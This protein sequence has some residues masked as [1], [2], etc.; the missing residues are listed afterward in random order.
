MTP[1]QPAQ[2]EELKL[3]IHGKS[4]E[5]RSGRTFESQN[6]YTG[7]AWARLADGGPEDIDEAVASAR[8]AFEVGMVSYDRL[9]ARG[10][11]SS[12][13]EFHDVMAAT[14]RSIRVISDVAR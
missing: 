14:T 13:G 6:H 12:R 1:P 2:L 7:T 8:A 4:V 9:R 5:A 10:Q 3:F 11:I